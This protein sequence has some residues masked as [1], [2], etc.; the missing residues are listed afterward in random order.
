MT[1]TLTRAEQISE[2]VEVVGRLREQGWRRVSIEITRGGT[3][4]VEA[5]AGESTAPQRHQ[6]KVKP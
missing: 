1:A 2:A 6:Y 3:Y 4:R 5:E